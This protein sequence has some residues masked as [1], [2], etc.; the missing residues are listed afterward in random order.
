MQA[1]EASEYSTIKVIAY[2]RVPVLLPRNV[3]VL[4]TI[5]GYRHHLNTTAS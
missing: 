5:C 4:A 2:T 3:T 1:S